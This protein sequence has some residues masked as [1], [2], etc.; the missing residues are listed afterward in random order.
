MRSSP[1]FLAAKAKRRRT[2]AE[3]NVIL[4]IPFPNSRIVYALIL[5]I[6]VMADIVPAHSLF[7]FV[8]SAMP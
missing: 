3:R 7:E 8:F 6:L 5:V 2:S 4:I 1:S